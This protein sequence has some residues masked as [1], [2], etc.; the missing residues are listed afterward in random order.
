ML[1]PLLATFNPISD[2]LGHKTGLSI[3]V[4]ILLWIQLIH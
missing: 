2:N 4:S 3:M 1:K